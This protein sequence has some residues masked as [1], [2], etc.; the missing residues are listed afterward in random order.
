MSNKKSKPKVHYCRKCGVVPV[1]VKNTLCSS[2]N[3][4]HLK[5][6]KSREN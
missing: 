6:I 1:L 3:K 2:C 5:T 4:A